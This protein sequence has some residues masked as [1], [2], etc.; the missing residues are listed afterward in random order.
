MDLVQQRERSFRTAGRLMQLELQ[1]AAKTNR[2]RAGQ[3]N[4]PSF[5]LGE[6]EA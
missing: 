2:L 6:D 4:L 3:K 5:I 1:H